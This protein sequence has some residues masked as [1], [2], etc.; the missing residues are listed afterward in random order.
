MIIRGLL[1]CIL[2]SGLTATGQSAR[3]V[4]FTDKGPQAAE[5]LQAPHTFLSEAALARRAR[6]NLAVE[7]RD[8]PL[9]DGYLDALRQVAAAPMARSRWLN[10]VVLPE[11]GTDWQAVAALPFVKEV[12]SLWGHP[13]QM[14]EAAPPAPFDTLA[15]GRAREQLTMLGL[16]Q[17]HTAQHLGQGIRMAVLDA[18]FPGVDTLAGFDSLRSRG[19]ILGTYDFVDDTTWA[20]GGASHG[21]RVLSTIA[22]YLPGEMLGAAPQANV[23]LFRTE[24]ARREMQIEEFNWVEAVEMADSLG[25]DIIH[26]SLGYNEFQDSPGYQ[27]EDLD[28]DKAI[29][30]K[31][32]DWAAARGILVVTSAGN[33]GRSS[34]RYITAPC[35]ADSALCVGSVTRWRDHSNFSSYGPSADGRIKPDVVA[36]GTGATTLGPTPRLQLSNGTSFAAPIVAG[37]AACLM[38]A[39][40]DRSNMEIIQAIRLSADQAGLPD[41][42]YGYGIPD[43]RQADSLLSQPGDIFSLTVAQRDKPRRGREALMEQPKP[44][45]SAELQAFPTHWEEKMLVLELPAAD[46]RLGEVTVRRGNQLVILPTGAMVRE[47]T[48]LRFDAEAWLPGKYLIE[49]S[50]PQGRSLVEVTVAP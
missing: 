14:A 7:P 49:V 50:S 6:W 21:T 48:R 45:S 26:S 47:G 42:T 16:D 33:Q 29:V 38:Q 34:W 23:Y 17:L 13:G 46:F 37:M 12:R 44:V 43:A 11:S 18:G 8:L 30:T 27:Y 19:G 9:Y 2:L 24:D 36:M 22:T 10:G 25:V 4:G 39:H 20:Y 15:Y 28:G 32:A 35:D 1:I 5:R 3:W 40:P 31:A 41:D